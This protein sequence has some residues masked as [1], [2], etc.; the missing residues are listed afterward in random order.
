MPRIY[1]RTQ[2]NLM[3]DSKEI[4]E[5]KTKEQVYYDV[6]M[7]EIG[8]NPNGTRT[9]IVYAAMEEYAKQQAESFTAFLKS[10]AFFTVSDWPGWHK[11]AEK[12]DGVRPWYSFEQIYNLWKKKQ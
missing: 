12:I 7:K 2:V 5:M 1:K 10:E 4:P 9:D 6:T 11:G 8:S 3:P